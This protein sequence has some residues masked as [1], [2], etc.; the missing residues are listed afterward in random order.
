[1]QTQHHN[2]TPSLASLAGEEHRELWQIAHTDAEQLYNCKCI[3]LGRLP[4]QG[5]F[6]G[7]TEALKW[8][9][10]LLIER[11]LCPACQGIGV[12][13]ARLHGRCRPLPAQAAEKA[14]A[15]G[16]ALL[17]HA[18]H[19]LAV[20]GRYVLALKAAHHGA[21][22]GDVR[23]EHLLQQRDEV[24][25]RGVARL[26]L[27]GLQLQH[28]APSAASTQGRKGTSHVGAPALESW[29]PLEDASRV[30]WPWGRALAWRLCGGLHS[31]QGLHDGSHDRQQCMPCYTVH[32]KRHTERAD[33]DCIVWL[34]CMGVWVGCDEQH[35]LQISVE[36]VE[37]PHLRG[38]AGGHEKSR[39]D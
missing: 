9:A 14:A 26:Q 20:R 22:V 29:D 28:A 36:V 34:Q 37:I 15:L 17:A 39:M 31:S 25:Q 23:P 16:G 24:Q 30:S 21:H 10:P 5:L 7:S 11:L 18:R 27:P 4:S 2:Q 35:L 3:Q 8:Q 6:S 13:H 19:A 1:M 33:L 32:D 38:Q 12:L